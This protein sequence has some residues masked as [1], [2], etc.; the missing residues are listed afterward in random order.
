MSPNTDPSD[1]LYHSFHVRDVTK[2]TPTT[3]GDLLWTGAI[4]G[5]IVL[6][7]MWNLFT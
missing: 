6:G 2:R 1:P 4:V 7:M 5:V 3:V